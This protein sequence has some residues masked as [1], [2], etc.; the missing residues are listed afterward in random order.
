[1]NR[2]TYQGYE[3]SISFDEDATL[4]HGEVLNLRDVVTFQGQSVADL[5]KAFAES[6][7]DYVAFCKQRGEEPERPYSG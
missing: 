3:A 1:M 7:D 6:I 5:K 2:M 4:F